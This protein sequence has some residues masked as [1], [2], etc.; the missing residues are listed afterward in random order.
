[1]RVNDASPELQEYLGILWR[2][3]WSIAV[4]V[5]IAVTAA[6]VYSSRQHPVYQSSTEVL[7]EPIPDYS[8]GQAPTP[9]IIIME[10][11][12]RVAASAEVMKTAAAVLDRAG[13]VMGA[14]SVEAA[15]ESH[16]LVFTAVSQDPV[17][18]QKTADAFAESYLSLRRK[19]ALG[20]L[21]AAREPI[22]RQ[23]RQINTQLAAAQQQ[24]STASTDSQ[25]TTA[26]TRLTNLLNQQS[27]LQQ[28]LN[29][30]VEP[31]K[32]R[33]GRVLQPA[34]P[35]IAAGQ[36]RSRTVALAL[37]MGLALG[38]GVA[39]L[40]DRLDQR[41]RSRHDLESLTGAPV[42]AVIPRRP[43]RSIGR[44]DRAEGAAVDAA[45]RTLSRRIL[46]ATAQRQLNTLMVTSPEEDD[47]KSA[48]T[49]SLAFALGEA[50]KS[51]V[52]VAAEPEK[53]RLEEHIADHVGMTNGQ[54]SGPGYGREPADSDQIDNP[55]L[56]L[57]LVETG[58]SMVPLPDS[59]AVLGTTAVKDFIDEL[60][61]AAD[62]VLVDASPILEMSDAWALTPAVDAVLCVTDGRHTRR[63]VLLDAMR[64]LHQVEAWVIGVVLT[65][66][67]RHDA[68][69]G[70]AL[71]SNSGGYRR[72]GER[73]NDQSLRP[74]R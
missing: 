1:M 9:G 6:L 64:E 71:S 2:R 65:K 43:W 25:R 39:F 33:L 48:T 52:I 36:S 70:T 45:Y 4:I 37:F 19:N 56:H 38:I 23:L 22:E 8:G 66:A 58:V 32:V 46:A 42:L 63:G 12:R 68:H 62:F 60:N 31:A 57:W 7:V 40:R 67:R 44:A 14:V 3:K 26:V 55:W 74:R 72:L 15:E 53:R 30:L 34:P 51:V 11:E 10:D 54:R 17:S 24:L 59:P 41:V 73:R 5:A 18:A 20:D 28:S 27:S 47:E 50:G 13:A 61:K 35:G 16:T 21:A 69:M 49:A 29:Q